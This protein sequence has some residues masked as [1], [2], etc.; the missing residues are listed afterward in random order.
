M[1]GKNILQKIS[2]KYSEKFSKINHFAQFF[3]FKMASKMAD[4][5]AAIHPVV[6]QDRR[7]FY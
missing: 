4:K 1:K 7:L 5:I 2:K 3:F 6:L